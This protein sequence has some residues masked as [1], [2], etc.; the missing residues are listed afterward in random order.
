MVHHWARRLFHGRRAGQSLEMAEVVMTRLLSAI[1]R[2]RD[3]LAAWR[4]RRW[5]GRRY[6]VVFWP[7]WGWKIGRFDGSMS[8]IYEWSARVGFVEIRRWTRRMPPKV[9]T[10][11]QH[12]AE[13]SPERKELVE[14]ERREILA[15]SYGGQDHPRHFRSEGW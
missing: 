10:V 8:L 6:Q 9:K 5:L 1:R 2:A 3:T 11:R 13:M 14:Q 7:S 15:A 4:Y 12:M